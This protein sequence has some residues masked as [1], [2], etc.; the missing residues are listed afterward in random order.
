ME[1]A[2]EKTVEYRDIEGFPGYRVG[3]DGSV[4]SSKKGTWT[5]CSS[6]RRPY[7]SR[8][9]VVCLRNIGPNGTTTTGKV[10]CCYIHRLVLESFVG[11]CPDGKLC[12]HFPDKDTSNNRLDNLSWG[13]QEQN[14]QDKYVHGT[15]LKTHCRRGHELTP[16]NTC[17]SKNGKRACRKCRNDTHRR[18]LE[19]RKDMRAVKLL[20]PLPGPVMQADDEEVMEQV[21]ERHEV[22]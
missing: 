20:P 8:Y 2:Q 3:S 10:Y 17:V 12:R 14:M 11:P 15:A 4:W 16:E 1:T 13:T 22:R 6:Y 18:Y 9:V 7:G 21:E 19:Q 5:K